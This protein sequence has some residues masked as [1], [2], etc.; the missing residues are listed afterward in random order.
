MNTEP[1]T[2]DFTVHPRDVGLHSTCWMDGEHLSRPFSEALPPDAA[3]LLD[4][5]LAIYAADRS[6]RRD[7]KRSNTG[8]RRIDVRLALRNPDYW[9]APET[10]DRPPG[11]PLLAQRRRVVVSS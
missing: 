10:A 1:Y 11:V 2:Y 3:D 9:T 5:A 4:L 7:H 8:Q 6:S